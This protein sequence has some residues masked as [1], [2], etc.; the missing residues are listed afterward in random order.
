MNNWNELVER[1]YQKVDFFLST[2]F[3]KPSCGLI[4][5]CQTIQ[6]V[7]PYLHESAKKSD[8][9]IPPVLRKCI[10]SFIKGMPQTSLF[11]TKKYI[12]PLKVP[13]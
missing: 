8:S 12:F 1:K 5:K 13:Q 3:T 4:L 2:K 11:E 10:D 9:I 6:T 7:V